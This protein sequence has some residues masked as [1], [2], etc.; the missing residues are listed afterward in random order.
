MK[1][2]EDYF[3]HTKSTVGISMTYLDGSMKYKPAFRERYRAQ[4]RC[5][6]NIPNTKQERMRKKPNV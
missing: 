6:T 4:E 2:I 3:V 1:L 5:V